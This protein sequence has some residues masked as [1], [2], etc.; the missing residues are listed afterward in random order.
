L[1]AGLS[2]GLGLII[3]YIGIPLLIG[4]LI[5]GRGLGG[6]ERLLARSMLSIN[7]PKPPAMPTNAGLLGQLKS[8]LTDSVTWKSLVYLGLKF[9]F[10]IASFSVLVAF[11]SASLALIF[12]PLYYRAFP[13]DIGFW[14][15][16]TQDQAAV[17]CMIGVVLLLLSFHLVNGLAYLWGRFA[18]IMLGPEPPVGT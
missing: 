5:A 11:L 18:Q 2:T 16:E 17:C 12:E 7:I 3:I 6:F 8:L 9:P 1:V 13:T 14:R 15:I 10:G 4:V